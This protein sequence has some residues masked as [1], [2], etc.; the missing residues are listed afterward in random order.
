MEYAS[1][2]KLETPLLVEK[3]LERDLPA[4]EEF[5]RRF[6]RVIEFS[7]KRALSKYSHAGFGESAKDI[8]QNIFMSLWNNN[9]LAEITNRRNINYWL[10]ITARNASVDYLRK[11]KKH[12]LV[13]DDSY[14]EKLP[15]PEARRGETGADTEDLRKKI[16]NACAFLAPKEKII[17]KLYFK[18]SL[19]TARIA[20]ILNISRGNVTSAISRIRKKIHRKI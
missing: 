15:A 11:R 20:K 8:R 9:K 6:G 3:C 4:W 17:F 19:K 13:G 16:K 10:V 7:V 12:V 18:R 14:F 2:K 1:Y 5:V